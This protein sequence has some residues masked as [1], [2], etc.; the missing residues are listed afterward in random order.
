MVSSSNFGENMLGLP[1]GDE[2]RAGT[3]SD[4]F[5]IPQLAV[6][7]IVAQD[8]GKLQVSIRIPAMMSHFSKTTTSLNDLL[9]PAGPRC[10]LL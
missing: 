5:A 10:Q 8:N 1:R 6:D 4:R 9:I 7:Q 2:H 3:L